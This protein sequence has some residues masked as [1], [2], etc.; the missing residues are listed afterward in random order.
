MMEKHGL[1]FWVCYFWFLF[2]DGVEIPYC[3]AF[4]LEMNTYFFVWRLFVRTFCF[5]QNTKWQVFHATVKSTTNIQ[6]PPKINLTFHSP[7][8]RSV[9]MPAN[10]DSLEELISKVNDTPLLFPPLHLADSGDTPSPNFPTHTSLVPHLHISRDPVALP[11]SQGLAESSH[12]H[13]PSSFQLPAPKSLH[14]TSTP[15]LSP[16]GHI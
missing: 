16:S 5:L 9:Q 1:V 13:T 14:R 12:L 2:W 6:G 15:W 10:I 4:T 3:L 11:T 7:I 8:L